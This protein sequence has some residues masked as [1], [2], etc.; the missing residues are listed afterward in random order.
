MKDL[1]PKGP[2]AIHANEDSAGFENPVDFGEQPVLQDNGRHMMEHCERDNPRE[3]LVGEWHRRRIAEMY[4]GVG[5]RSTL[6]K[7]ESQTGI[8]FETREAPVSMAQPIRRQARPGSN[9]Q[10]VI[11]QLESI[12]RPWQYFTL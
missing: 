7:R 2:P 11:A 3:R 10:D 8:H 6:F 12:E 4:S 9:L 5:F 1:H